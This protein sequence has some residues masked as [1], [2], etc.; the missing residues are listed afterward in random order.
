MMRKLLLLITIV[1]A[2][3]AMNA[4]TLSNALWVGPVTESD[5]N[6]SVTFNYAGVTVGTHTMEWQVKTANASGG[7]DFG[8]P[9]IAYGTNIAFTSSGSGTQTVTRA[10]GSGGGSPT[11]TNG[12]EIIWFGKIVGPSGEIMTITSNVVVVGASETPLLS[13]ALW[14]SNVISSDT[15]FSVT[16]DFTGITADNTMEWQ[17]KSAN[18]SG[19][20]DFGSPTIA[21]G[22]GLTFDNLGSGTQTITLSLGS[23]GGSPTI[24]NG[25]EIIWF[26]KLNDLSGEVMTL[27]S[28]VTTV[29]DTAGIDDINSNGVIIYPNP[30]AETL[31][32]KSNHLDANTFSFIDVLGRT[33]LVID[34]VQ[35]V[36]SVNLSTLNKGMYILKTDTNR[37]FR[38]LKK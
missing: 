7:V 10:L 25:Q 11:I 19:G 16:F 31:Y 5:T 17:V 27:S 15:D 28:N 38:F 34:N 8:S 35:N 30:V 23:G 21:F 1:S 2:T 13:N 6:F 4:Q 9:T 36:E 29:T 18:A 37:Q 32:I 26:G 22:S 33:V 24:V 12:Q 3:F 20:V 14:T